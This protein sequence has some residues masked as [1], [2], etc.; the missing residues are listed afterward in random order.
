MA[1]K[2]YKDYRFSVKQVNLMSQLYDSGMTAD[3]VIAGFKQIQDVGNP[4]PPKTP[5]PVNKHDNSS[6]NSPQSYHNLT[7]DSEG[8]SFI[9]K[10]PSSSEHN[11]APS[12]VFTPPVYTQPQPQP[13]GEITKRR[14]S[15]RSEADVRARGR[16][17]PKRSK[18]D[19]N[20]TDEDRINFSPDVV[21]LMET[22]LLEVWG[23]IT[24]FMKSNNIKIKEICEAS[25]GILYY[26]YVSN[27]LKKPQTFDKQKVTALYKWYTEAVQK[28]VSP[29]SISLMIENTP[30]VMESAD[31]PVDTKSDDVVM[32]DSSNDSSPLSSL[33]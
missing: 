11:G 13:L 24:A 5:S 30:V 14:G 22:D 29:E 20:V 21:L 12:M 23:K 8:V 16:G 7:Q 27:W 2:P 25:D 31:D 33:M 1:S 9:F 10:T 26:S 4:T 32:E 28:K 17:R 19:F 6:F 15:G 3:D 18:V